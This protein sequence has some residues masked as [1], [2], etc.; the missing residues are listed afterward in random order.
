MN[1]FKWIAILLIGSVAIYVNWGIVKPPA[2][3]AVDG[4]SPI[5]TTNSPAH[6][7]YELSILFIGNSYTFVNNLPQMMVGHSPV[8][9]GQPYA[10][11]GAIGNKGR[12]RPYR[13]ME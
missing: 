5:I 8:R 3:H 1:I 9:S 13:I 10:L 7:T 6:P 11:C 4:I 12:Y 2:A